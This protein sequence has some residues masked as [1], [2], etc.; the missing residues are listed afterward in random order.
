MQIARSKTQFLP[1]TIL[2]VVGVLVWVFTPG[3]V[4][5]YYEAT[6]AE[7]AHGNNDPPP[8]YGVNRSEAG[9]DIGD[10]ANCHD[11]FDD[12]ICGVNPLMLFEIDD[13]DSQTDN[14]CFQC[15][16]SDGAAQ[17]VTN[18]TYSTN[19]G[20]GTATFATIYDAFNPTTGAIP[21]SHN[22]KDI[23]D[24][25]TDKVGFT[26]DSNPC[27]VCHNPHTAQDNHPVNLSGRGGV[28]TA[29]RK[30][31]DYQDRNSNLWGDE[32]YT[33]SGYYER[34][35]DLADAT[36][37]SYMAPYYGSGPWDPE[38][39]PFEPAND[40]F[41]DG[42]NLPNFATFCWDCHRYNVIY[43]TD[44]GRSLRPVNWTTSDTEPGHRNVHGL[45]TFSP[46]HN[47]V[48]SLKPPYNDTTNYVLSCT[49][50]HEP[51]GSPNEYLL[52]TSVNG[53]DNIQI[54]VSGYYA[55]FCAA[56]HY[57]NAD[58]ILHTSDNCGGTCHNHDSSKDEF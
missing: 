1:T 8:G 7:S 56:C 35:K 50:C 58:H 49:D 15:H 38:D 33:T 53:T 42:S 14:F 29:I 47:G 46:R 39:G 23:Q 31:L 44:Q 40:T 52:R 5:A 55:E 26:S 48:G 30:V 2:I 3:H 13:P 28:N 27:V 43:S 4:I 20:G 45:Y 18:Y 36:S 41:S 51:H 57:I 32:D 25:M 11:T 19:F 22:L 16:K 9:H 12:S 17:Q 21:S 24:W 54:P 34:I 10:C 6:Y 37:T